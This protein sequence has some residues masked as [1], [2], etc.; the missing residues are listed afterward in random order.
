MKKIKSP[1]FQF[2]WGILIG[3]GYHEE[4]LV[5]ALPCLLISFDVH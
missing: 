3:I 2:Y 1:E 5:I 4:T